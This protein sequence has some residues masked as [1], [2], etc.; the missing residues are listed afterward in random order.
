MSY[1]NMQV[2]GDGSVWDNSCSPED[3]G[4]HLCSCSC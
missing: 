2:A 4:V 1:K 3:E